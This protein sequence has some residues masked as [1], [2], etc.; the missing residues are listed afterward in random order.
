MAASNKRQFLTSQEK[1]LSQINLLA[2]QKDSWAWFLREGIG[3]VLKEI[4]PVVDFTG[5]NWE[6]SFGE[7]RTSAPEIT[8]AKAREKGLTFASGLYV[9]ATLLNKRTGKTTSQ[10]VF[11]GDIPQITSEGTFIINGIER[12]VVNQIVRS[13]GVYFSGEIDQASGRMLYRAE[14]RPGS[15]GSWL[16]FEVSRGD[17]IIAR[18]DRR[19]KIFASTLLRAMGLEKDEDILSKFKDADTDQNHSYITATITKDPTRNRDEALLEI[20][21]KMRSGELVVLDNAT[22]LFESLFTDPRR[23]DLGKVGRHKINKKLAVDMPNTPENWVLKLDDVVATLQ[24]LVKLQN[25]E[26]KVWWQDSYD[27]VPDPDNPRCGPKDG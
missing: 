16:E 21:R 23:Y 3:E 24:Y 10:E 18:I 22:T 2:I 20:Y 13:P 5:K 12:A 17:A 19:R 1:T 27:N 25:G 8:P 4:S 14:I 7:Y 26:G 15:R 9:Q 6:L 11:L